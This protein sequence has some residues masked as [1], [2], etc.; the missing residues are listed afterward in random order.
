MPVNMRSLVQTL[1]A[2]PDTA[3]H[4]YS[5]GHEIVMFGPANSETLM[6]H[7]T[8]HHLDWEG[9]TIRDGKQSPQFSSK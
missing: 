8:G 2:L 7:E 3:S 1:V 9:L 5:V 6:I 4:A